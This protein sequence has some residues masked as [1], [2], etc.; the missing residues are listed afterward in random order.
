[1]AK[2]ASSGV[3]TRH[4]TFYNFVD[5]FEHN[6]RKMQTE[7]II[8]NQIVISNSKDA[9]K[10]T[11]AKQHKERNNTYPWPLFCFQTGIGLVS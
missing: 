10:I 8:L 7:P 5:V 1:M 6:G 9:S 4:N 2:N 11:N 3:R